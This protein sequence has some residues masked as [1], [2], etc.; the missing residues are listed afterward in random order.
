MKGEM[1]FVRNRAL[2]RLLLASFFLYIAWPRIHE[3]QEGSA[4]LFWGLWLVFFLI[5]AG[6]NLAILLQ[7]QP[8]PAVEQK[9]Q[10][11]KMTDSH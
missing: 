11:M 4:M 3:A 6:A 7:L 5:C 2:L 1:E 9:K 8:R 10:R